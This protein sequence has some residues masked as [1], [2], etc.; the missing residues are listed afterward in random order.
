MTQPLQAPAYYHYLQPGDA[1]SLAVHCFVE[2]R[3]LSR[4]QKRALLT[5]ATEKDPPDD[6]P[7]RLAIAL[8]ALAKDE[9]TTVDYPLT[10]A[11]RR[12]RAKLADK[13]VNKQFRTALFL[14]GGG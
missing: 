13:T 6:R 3:P 4:E 7:R 2:G 1:V 5:A 8:L 12:L 9:S 14:S 10:Q 11:L